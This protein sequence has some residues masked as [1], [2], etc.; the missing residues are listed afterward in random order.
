MYANNDIIVWHISDNP[1]IS[2]HGIVYNI[3]WGGTMVPDDWWSSWW[4]TQWQLELPLPS[5]VSGRLG[6][7]IEKFQ[8]LYSYTRMLYILYIAI[9]TSGYA[10]QRLLY[11]QL[12]WLWYSQ[13]SSSITSKWHHGSIPWL[14]VSRSHWPT[15]FKLPVGAVLA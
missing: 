11:I 13:Q 2:Y 15:I 1:V 10:I 8:K 6:C 9:I 5:R 7:A 4:F 3:S 14:C 12:L